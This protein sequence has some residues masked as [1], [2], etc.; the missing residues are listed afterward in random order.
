[1]QVATKNQ[2]GNIWSEHWPIRLS[3]CSPTTEPASASQCLRPHC[4]SSLVTAATVLRPFFVFFKT[5]GEGSC[6][7]SGILTSKEWGYNTCLYL[8][9]DN[10]S[11]CFVNKWGIKFDRKGALTDSVIIKGPPNS[12]CSWW[13]LPVTP[14]LRSIKTTLGYVASLCLVTKLSDCQ[15]RGKNSFRENHVYCSLW[16]W[17]EY[18]WLPLLRVTHREH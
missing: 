3:P 14:A 8:A 11:L 18:H 7:L 4:L 12:S 16:M 10:R 2:V 1:M 13:L 9:W 6:Y 17:P 5:N 15:H